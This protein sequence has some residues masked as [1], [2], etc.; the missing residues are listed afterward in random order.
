MQLAARALRE[1]PA[2]DL[3][4]QKR[5]PALPT[6]RDRN[7]HEVSSDEA[8]PTETQRQQ[9]SGGGHRSGSRG[10][11]TFENS[12]GKPEPHQGPKSESENPLRP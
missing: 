1:L 10:T 2:G 8:R 7:T 5:S 9:T 4:N 11:G 6:K 12:D 3:M